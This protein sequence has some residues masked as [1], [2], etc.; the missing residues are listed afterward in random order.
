MEPG[1]MENTRDRIVRILTDE[2]MAAQSRHN[3]ASK[4]LD[5]L[6]KEVPSGLPHPD[7]AHRIRTAG[8]EANVALREHMHALKRYTDFLLH[9]IVP[10]DLDLTKTQPD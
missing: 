4:R 7:G 1:A 2:L 3:A 10:D 5:C 9:G 8:R 6:V